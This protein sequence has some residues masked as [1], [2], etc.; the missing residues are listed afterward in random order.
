[1]KIIHVVHQ[2]KFRQNRIDSHIQKTSIAIGC[3]IFGIKTFPLFGDVENVRK[4]LW[5]LVKSN[6][7][8]DHLIRLRDEDN[9]TIIVGREEYL[10]IANLLIRFLDWYR[11]N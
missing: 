10:P 8:P 4:S 5:E 3:T 11:K 2:Q 9:I 7:I 1:M 6:Q